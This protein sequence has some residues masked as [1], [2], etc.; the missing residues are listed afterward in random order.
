VY[1]ALYL[2]DRTAQNFIRGVARKCNITGSLLI[3]VIGFPKGNLYREFDDD[4]V[5]NLR[6]EQNIV[7]KFQEV[8]LPPA[9]RTPLAVDTQILE[10]YLNDGYELKGP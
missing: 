2:R 3:E 1:S 10:S 6:E 9:L 4:S 7:A 5:R 8:E